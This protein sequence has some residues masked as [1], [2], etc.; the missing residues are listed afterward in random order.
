M[1]G[2]SKDRSDGAHKGMGVNVESDMCDSMSDLHLE[3]R[4]NELYI[5]LSRKGLKNRNKKGE[6]KLECKH[7]KESGHGM[8]GKVDLEANDVIVS[9]PKDLLI[10]S[11]T[12]RY[13]RIGKCISKHD[14]AIK[15]TLERYF[16]FVDS[17]KG[18]L[19]DFVLDEANFREMSSQ[20][21][22][23]DKR[24]ED[25][26]SCFSSHCLLSLF[27]I[28]ESL[29]EHSL[30]K[31]Y[32]NSIPK[33][34]DTPLFYDKEE[35]QLLPRDLRYRSYESIRTCLSN[36]HILL[37]CAKMF[38]EFNFPERNEM[39]RLWMW[40]WEAVGTRSVYFNVRK[41]LG[42]KKTFASTKE[43]PVAFAETL[44]KSSG[45]QH[46]IVAQVCH[47]E[48]SDII[49]HDENVRHLGESENDAALAPFLDML[50][51]SSEANVSAGF[52]PDSHCY[53]IK[54]LV[55][56][57]KDREV[58]VS[59]GAH[60]N[61]RLLID[62][63]FVLKDNCNN[64]VPMKK[65][66]MNLVAKLADE[67][68]LCPVLR[69][70]ESNAKT[71]KSKIEFL[72]QRGLFKN[73]FI[74]QDGP[75]WNLV[76]CLRVLSNEIAWSKTV[77]LESLVSCPCIELTGMYSLPSEKELNYGNEANMLVALKNLIDEE[78]SVYERDLVNV[79]EKKKNDHNEYHLRCI[80]SIYQNRVDMLKQSLNIVAY[81][82]GQF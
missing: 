64:K 54:T 39:E 40:A 74:S 44:M 63:G 7:F 32:I 42:T 71:L 26:A 55:P 58:F 38:P 70:R 56:L 59:Y 31:P 79:E 2:Q 11:E 13:S 47:P 81:Y 69:Q 36:F 46:S 62:Y 17:K 27:L 66:L 52:N 12:V 41:E 78:L 28:S 22:H 72:K 16:D 51:H 9:I 65:S 3:S 30:W 14:R 49:A 21:N 76:S 61:D 75:S 77:T 82:I 4:M 50:N 5:W 18:N 37:L 35:L 57:Q 34:F 67:V 25:R 10:T 73:L 68:S 8:V 1:S 60:N 20:E 43:T 29:D 80:F 53:E 48:K 24:N 19:D 23:K 45:H 6:K 15:K 33:Q